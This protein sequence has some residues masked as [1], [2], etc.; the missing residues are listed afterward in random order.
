MW[1]KQARHL[2]SA[3][4]SGTEAKRTNT[5]RMIEEAERRQEALVGILKKDLEH[6]LRM[7]RLSVCIC[8]SVAWHGLRMV[9]TGQE[10]VREKKFF[11]VREM[12]GNFIMGQGKLAF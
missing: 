7:V 4:K 10:M 8:F 11:K 3:L 1:Q 6:N 12:S 9:A 2:S 5:Q